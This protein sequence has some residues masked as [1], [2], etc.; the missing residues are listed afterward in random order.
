MNDERWQ[1]LIADGSPSFV[2][3]LRR[4]SPHLLGTLAA[5]GDA[6][7]VPHGTKCSRSGTATA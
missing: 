1:H 7:G 6:R 2:D 5:A 3:L 4:A